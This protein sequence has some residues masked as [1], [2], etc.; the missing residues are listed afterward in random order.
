LLQQNNAEDEKDGLLTSSL[1]TFVVISLGIRQAWTVLAAK[2]SWELSLK[3]SMAL[4]QPSHM[5]V[6]KEI[7]SKV[8]IESHQF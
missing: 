3:F 1:Y 7:N 8:K 6:C 2:G 4:S 5:R